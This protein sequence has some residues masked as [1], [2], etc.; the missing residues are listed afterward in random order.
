MRIAVD[1]DASSAAAA[2]DGTQRLCAARRPA[3]SAWHALSPVFTMSVVRHHPS[4]GAAIRGG[5]TVF[6][7]NYAKFAWCYATST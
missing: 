5:H 1:L 3:S 7:Q 6:A 2:R 4:S